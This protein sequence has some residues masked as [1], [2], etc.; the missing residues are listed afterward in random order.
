MGVFFC[1]FSVFFWWFCSF[2]FFFGG[3]VGNR[4]KNIL[5]LGS[6]LFLLLVLGFWGGVVVGFW[7][8]FLCLLVYN[9][10]K[11]L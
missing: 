6:G 9:Y 8:G 11:N 3:G 7:G 1:G 2:F 10:T 5:G 4:K